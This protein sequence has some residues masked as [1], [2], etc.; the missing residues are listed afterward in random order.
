[1]TRAG[2]APFL[3]AAQA[4]AEARASEEEGSSAAMAASDKD[5]ESLVGI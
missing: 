3:Q 4:A 1:M 2:A 5:M